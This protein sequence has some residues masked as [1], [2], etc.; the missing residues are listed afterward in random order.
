MALILGTVLSRYCIGG[1]MSDETMGREDAAQDAEACAEALESLDRIALG[2]IAFDDAGADAQ[3]EPEAEGEQDAGD[4]AAPA[5]DEA[6]HEDS[7]S[8]TDDQPKSDTGEETILLDSLPAEDSLTRELPGLGSAPAVDET[9]AMGDIPLPS[10]PSAREAEDRHRKM[11]PKRRNLM[12]A[13]VVAVALVAGG[14]GYAAWNG[15][16]QEQAATVAANA[17]TMMS[18]QIGV[19]APGLDCSTG[20]KIPVQVNGQDS[21]GSSVS[22]TLYVDEHG[23]GIKLLPGDYTLS[24]AASPIAADGTIYTVPTTKAQVTVKADGQDLRAQATFKLKVPSADTVTNDQIDAAAKYAEE[25]GASSAAT[26]KVLQQAATARRDAAANAVSAQN[27]Q[28]ARDADARHKA[29]NLYQLD[30]PVEWYGKVATWQNGSTLCIYLDG[31]TNTPIVTLV[32]VRDGESFTPDEGDTVLGAANLGN[33][34]TV[35]ASGP[36]YP[37]VIPQ[38]INGRT[39]DPVSTYPMDTAIELVE[40][41][42]GNRYTYSQIKNDLVG[43]DGKANAATKLETDY[44]AQILLP[45]IKAQD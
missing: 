16:Q 13:G 27:A 29:T 12:V 9:I 8:E 42:T 37:Y 11:T 5:E 2:E 41:T 18:V 21:D 26:A 17:H 45:S 25:G 36:V 15:Y 4:D 23:R 28:A 40:L 35:Y 3:D 43:K 38:T 44:L 34:Y 32:A 22:E 33:G 39:Q 10:V 7:E 6:D 14:A 30:I 20:S 24:I 31:D 1:Y 19:H